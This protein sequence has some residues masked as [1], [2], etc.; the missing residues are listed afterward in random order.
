MKS[1]AI[2]IVAVLCLTAVSAQP[3]PQVSMPVTVAPGTEITFNDVFPLV[4]T[5][6][7]QNYWYYLRN[8]NIIYQAEV[9]TVTSFLFFV[10]YRNIVGTFLV[11]DT[12]NKAAQT[13]QVNTFVRLGDGY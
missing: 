4:D 11:I 10:I 13:S 7:R 9:S 1:I 5:Y 8:A 3:N 6:L 12:W 2:L